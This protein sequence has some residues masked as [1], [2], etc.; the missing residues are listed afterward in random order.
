VSKNDENDSAKTP[1]SSMHSVKVHITG[2][3]TPAELEVN[4]QLQ[5]L[6]S[7]FSSQ[8]ILS[9]VHHIYHGMLIPEHCVLPDLDFDM[10]PDDWLV[11]GYCKSG[12]G[13]LLIM[14]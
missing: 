9:R 13:R 7:R 5:Q 14:G 2:Q 6:H 10:R 1:L 3:E 12:K 8:S 11:C 4:Q